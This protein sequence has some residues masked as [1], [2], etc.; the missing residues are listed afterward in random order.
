[1]RINLISSKIMVVVAIV[2]A[3]ATLMTVSA[4]DTNYRIGPGDVIDVIVNPAGSELSR[5]GIRVTNQGTIQLP[6]LD[7]EI[8]AGCLTERELADQL[9]EKYKKYVINPNVIVAVQQFNS[10]PVAVI[11]AVNTPG[12]FQL[13]RPV[14]VLELLGWVNGTAERAGPSIEIIRN[15]SLPFCDGSQLV[16]SGGVEDELITLNIADIFKGTEG[17]N[18]Y[19]RAGDII[20]ISD[21]EITRAY[22]VGNVKNAMAI[23]LKEPVA[24]T[25]AIAMAGGLAPEARSEKI[26]I[27]RQ[28]S[29][30]VN[31][32]EILANLKEINQRKTND[33]LLQ[34]NDIVE[35][36]GPKPNIFKDILKTIV[37]T[38]GSLPMRVIPIP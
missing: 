35:V 1:M 2:F 10:N 32:T 21:A 14:R 3:I 28:I 33:I 8:Q 11:G 36:P 19:A 24:L 4:Q 38:I 29:G 5:T 20:R 30:S 18:P 6:K 37:P 26:V 13:Q 9:K 12:R 31:R 27:R 7:S 25:Q 16:L 23:S 22:V 34:S 17:A 15:R